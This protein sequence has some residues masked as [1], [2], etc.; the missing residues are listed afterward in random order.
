ML[1]ARQSRRPNTFGPE[2]LSAIN[3]HKLTG[4]SSL[5]SIASKQSDAVAGIARL[6]AGTRAN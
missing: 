4:L 3:Q 6:R 2:L 5:P 1:P